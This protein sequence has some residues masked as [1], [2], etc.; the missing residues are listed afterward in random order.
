MKYRPTIGLEIHIELKTRSKMFCSCKNDPNEKRANFN[1]CPVCL[2]HP[3]TLPV[4]N[5][6]AVRKTIKT[7]LALNCKISKESKFDRKN[8]FYPDLPKG[9]QISQ[10]DKPL[11]KEGFLKIDDKK[12]RITRIHLEED[13]GKL[14]HSEGNYSL[15]DFNRAGI[16][17]MELVTEP[18]LTSPQQARKFAQEL[19]LI[20]RYLGVSD[21][22]M[23]KG[24]MRVEANVSLSKDKKLGTKVEIKN[25]NSFRSVEKALEYE[26][27]RQAA[28]LDSG[29]EIIQETRGWDE[30]KERTVSQREKEQAHDYRYFPEPDLPTLYFDKEF[31]EEIRAEIP[32]L[33]QEKRERFAKEYKLGEKT[34]EIFVQNKDLS[35]YFEKV[36][37]ELRNWIKEEEQKK[38]VGENEYRKLAKVASNYITSDLQGLINLSSF[39]EDKFQITPENFAEFVKLIYKG[40]I[41]SKIAK[42]VLQEMFKTGADPSNIIE[43]KGLTQLTDERELERIVKEVISNNPEPV[44]DYKKGKEAALQFLIG[45]VMSATRGRANPGIVNK[46]L[47]KF[48]QEGQTKKITAP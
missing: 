12:I 27:E 5:K 18:D 36:M 17:L 46:L 20:L 25:L 8:Y 33:P 41:S 21:A 14:L 26:I 15:V 37:S 23:E 13:T 32:E 16:P 42:T 34:I 28:L 43:D 3:G 22:D 10:Y 31:I 2:G 29:G 44:E 45:Q 11:C 9:Y 6:E 24:Q 40:E 1:I 38:S 48:L 47:R 39:K 30:K 35:E 7:G 4:I 19:R